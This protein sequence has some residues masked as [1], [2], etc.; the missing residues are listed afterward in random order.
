MKQEKKNLDRGKKAKQ[1]R[2]NISNLV[3]SLELATC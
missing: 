1:T 3:K 2:T